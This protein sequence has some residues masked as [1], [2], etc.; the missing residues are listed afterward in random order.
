MYELLQHSQQCANSQKVYCIPLLL[1]HRQERNH[2]K[3]RKNQ[4]RR[5]QYRWYNCHTALD[6]L[7]KRSR[8]LP[9]GSLSLYIMYAGSAIVP[10]TSSRE[11]HPRSIVTGRRIVGVAIG[12]FRQCFSPT[13]WWPKITKK[14]RQPY[15]TIEIQIWIFKK[16]FLCM[17]PSL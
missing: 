4:R 6:Q 1:L 14:I 15:T 12:R 7:S 17:S 13:K 9:Q 11:A 3:I 10:S 2:V 5:C 16:E 8:K